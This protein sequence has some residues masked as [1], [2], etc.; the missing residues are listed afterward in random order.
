[1]ALKSSS[2]TLLIVRQDEPPDTGE[3]GGLFIDMDAGYP[4]LYQCTNLSP[5][6][7]TSVLGGGGGASWGSIT[8]TLSAQTD[9]QTALDGKQPIDA[10][11]TALAAA[12]NS[13]V[14]AAT[15]EAF[16]VADG[17][18]LDGIA[19]EATVGATWGSNVAGQPAVI[20]QA[21]AEAGVATTER[22][23]TA[24]RVNQAIQA[25]APGG[26]GGLSSPQILARTLG[27]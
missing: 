26:G 6:T 27:A 16:L 8:G 21:E 2:N 12:G 25:L 15:T 5:L 17:T 23:F 3:L 20:S 13:A 11:L 4:N 1:V 7:Y 14:L 24:E 22:I 18:K 10:D 9:L 19:A